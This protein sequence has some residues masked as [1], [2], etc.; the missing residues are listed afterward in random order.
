MKALVFSDVHGA[1]DQLRELVARLPRLKCDL[2]LFCGD[3]VRGRAR[4]AEFTAARAEGRTPNFHTPEIEAERGEDY[5]LYAE[6]YAILR[7]V[8]FRIFA[9][10][11]NMDAPEGRYTA[12]AV[13]SEGLAAAVESVHRF[14]AKWHDWV[15]VGMGGQITEAAREEIFMLMFPRWEADHAFGLF[16]L[17]PGPRIMVLHTPPLGEVVDLDGNKHKGCQVVND[18]IHHWRPALAV[19]GHAHEARGHEIIGETLV[20]NPGALKNGHFA[21]VDL[22]SKEVRLLDL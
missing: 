10:P 15:I 5:A 22:E 2:G 11:G 13:G 19:C 18:L 4:A 7:P 9:V 17:I 14:A 16:E 3:I 8:E 6:F 20:V 21:T 12:A 1:M